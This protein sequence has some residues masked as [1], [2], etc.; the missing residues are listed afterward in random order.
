MHHDHDH[1]WTVPGPPILT[2]P[3]EPPATCAAQHQVLHT[4][5]L[6]EKILASCG[7]MR[8]VL[9]AQ[10]VNLF[11]HDLIRD[12][13]LLQCMLYFEAV[14]PFAPDEGLSPEE[15]WDTFSVNPLL[16]HYFPGWL[17][18]HKR[19]RHLYDFSAPPM[20]GVVSFAKDGCCREGDGNVSIDADEG[21]GSGMSV[22]PPF[23]LKHREAFTRAGASWRRMLVCQ[24]ASMGLGFRQ[25]RRIALWPGETQEARQQRP[26]PNPGWRQDRFVQD[27]DGGLAR[28]RHIIGG[29]L[30]TSLEGKVGKDDMSNA[31]GGGLR[32]G[33]LFDICLQQYLYYS[34]A[35]RRAEHDHFQLDWMPPGHLGLFPYETMVRDYGS[36][37]PGL[38]VSVFVVLEDVAYHD[39]P[40]YGER[41]ATLKLLTTEDLETFRCEE[42]VDR[43]FTPLQVW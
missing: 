31:D 12:S 27:D 43:Q 25:T 39:A 15:L 19:P 4:P 38:G 17:Q 35:E 41:R 7:D 26:W 6:L 32:M 29:F 22:V 30:D 3:D 37:T 33:T 40:R 21:E 16:C 14:P 9:L 28:P 8:A 13:S 23:P 10:R 34:P 11:W 2:Q 20:C 36:F 42:H 5:E 18:Q 1:E 24:P